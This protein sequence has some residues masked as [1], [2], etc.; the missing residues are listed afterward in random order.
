[1]SEW[2]TGRCPRCGRQIQI[3]D[4]CLAECSC[5]WSQEVKCQ[6]CGERVQVNAAIPADRGYGCPECEERR[7]KEAC[8]WCGEPAPEPEAVVNGER[9]CKACRET[10]PECGH[11][12]K[13][14]E[15]PYGCEIELGDYPAPCK[16]GGTILAARGPCGC[17]EK[18]AE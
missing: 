8:D 12:W 5:G 9:L 14:H 3:E 2:S 15:S 7:A 16:D 1:M 4:G 18:R 10:C 13:D 17:M 6:D 11:A